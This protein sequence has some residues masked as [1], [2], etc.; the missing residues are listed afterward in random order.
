MTILVIII[1]NTRM[2]TSIKVKPNGDFKIKGKE[3][4][5]FFEIL[6]K[7]EV[8]LLKI[9]FIILMYLNLNS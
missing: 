2:T 7:S 1:E 5:V 4:L 9:L 6:E 8:E 3:K